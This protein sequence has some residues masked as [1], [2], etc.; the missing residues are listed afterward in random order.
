MK[1]AIFNTESNEIVS[2]CLTSD[3][4]DYQM[5]GLNKVKHN[6]LK[7]IESPKDNEICINDKGSLIF[8]DNHKPKFLEL[9]Y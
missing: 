8:K 1:L 2:R 7:V 4:V 3:M 9:N 6:Y 5:Y